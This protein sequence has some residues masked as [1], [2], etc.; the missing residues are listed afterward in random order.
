MK[1][2]IAAS[3][4]FLCMGAFSW[5]QGSKTALFDVVKS[6]QEMEIMKQILGTTLSFV[7]QNV[8]RQQAASK[9]VNTPFG[10]LS[11]RGAYGFSN[12]NCFY[13][14]GQGAVFVLPSSSLRFNEL[15]RTASLYAEQALRAYGAESDA[16]AKVAGLPPPPAPPKPAIAPAPPVPPAKAEPA[17]QEELRKRLAEAQEKVKKS[18]EDTEA[19]HAKF[20]ASLGEIKSYLI[21]ALATHGDSLTTVKPNEYITLVILLDDFGDRNWVAADDSGIRTRQEIV[22]IQ[23]SWIT[24]FKAGRLTMEAFKQKALQYAQ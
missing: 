2:Y 3:L 4:I 11:T 6:Q 7:A 15:G 9:Q 10:V 22:S 18:R 21:E 5:A 23:K 17:T 8:Q 14:Y 16:L 20:I 24:D 19:R 13:L 12:I 1:K